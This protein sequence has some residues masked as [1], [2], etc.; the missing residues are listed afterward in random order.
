M[1]STISTEWRRN[2]WENWNT[3][4][5]YL[6]LLVIFAVFLCFA[7]VSLLKNRFVLVSSLS[8]I[9]VI[10]TI[11]TLC[12]GSVMAYVSDSYFY[13]SY[14]ESVHIFNCIWV[15]CIFLTFIISLLPVFVILI[16]NLHNSWIQTIS[17]REH[18]YKRVAKMHKYLEKGI[19]TEEE[20]EQTKK[21][22]LKHIV[23]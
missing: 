11:I 6:V 22:I 7:I 21:E 17:Y 16:K 3:T 2:L 15:V 5:V 10:A 23:K 4:N 9:P 14:A 1:L 18:C 19:I 12:E 13:Y 20:Y 8:P